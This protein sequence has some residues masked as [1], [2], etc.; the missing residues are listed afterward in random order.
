MSASEVCG[1]LGVIV[2]EKGEREKVG[3]KMEF[4]EF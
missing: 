4:Q 1:G 3:I 2:K